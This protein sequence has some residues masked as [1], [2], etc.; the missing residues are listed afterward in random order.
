MPFWALIGAIALVAGGMMVASAMTGDQQGA[1]VSGSPSASPSG[2]DKTIASPSSS[3]SPSAEPK[4]RIVIHGTGDVS[5]DPG[6]IST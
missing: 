5:L 1:G 3:P 2:A 6:Y 4:G